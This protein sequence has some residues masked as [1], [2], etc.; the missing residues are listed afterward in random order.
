MGDQATGGGRPFKFFNFLAN[1]SQFIPIVSEVW[2]QHYPGAMINVIWRKLK[3][4]K[5]KLKVFHF[6]EF[7]NTRVQQ[8]EKECIGKLKKWLFV[9]ECAL[10]QK[11]RNMWLRVGDSNHHYFFALMKERFTMNKIFT[12]YDDQG[13]R[14]SGEQE[15]RKEIGDFYH[16]LLGIVATSLPATELATVRKGSSL[17]SEACELLI[18]PVTDAEIDAALYSISD[19]EAPGLDG[20]NSVFFKASWSIIKCD[21]LLPWEDAYPC[22]LHFCNPCAKGETPHSCEGIQANCLLFYPL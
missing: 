12:L 15:I 14:L 2:A 5:Q 19:L 9:E 13:N 11:A 8:T 4:I 7:A 18:A 3:I 10:K 22:Q 17:S 1:H 6:E 21:V 16:L 20:F